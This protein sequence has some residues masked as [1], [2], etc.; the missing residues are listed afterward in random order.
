MFTIT[1]AAVTI[2]LIMQAFGIRIFGRFQGS[3]NVHYD[4]TVEK[5]NYEEM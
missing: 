3:G 4:E 5:V 1:F 2:A